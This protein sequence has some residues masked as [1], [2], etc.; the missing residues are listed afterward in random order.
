MDALVCTS[1]QRLGVF[2]SQF[3]TSAFVLE[4]AGDSMT[5]GERE[6]SVVHELRDEVPA[7]EAHHT[8]LLF[9]LESWQ[10]GGIV[11]AGTPCT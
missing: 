2:S 6:R 5:G 9:L 3:N 4:S 11:R 1:Q 8:W 10:V 7:L